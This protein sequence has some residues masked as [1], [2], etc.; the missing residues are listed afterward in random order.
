M[1][2][3]RQLAAGNEVELFRLAPNLHHDDTHR[4]ADKRVRSRPQRM[5]HVGG[6]YSY[7]KAGIE[8]ELDQPAHRHHAR[9]NL[10]EILAYPHDGP[11]A[12]RP[13]RKRSHKAGR[14]SA[15]PAGC[16]KHLMHGA[17]SESA[18]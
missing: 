6:A 13:A 7:E 4:I 5:V 3:Q 17:Q 9:F 1:C 18:L 2:R 16:R 12:R 8:T 11:A 14:R 15:L 10:G